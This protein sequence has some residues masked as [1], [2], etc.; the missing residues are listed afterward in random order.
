MISIFVEAEW[1]AC[2]VYI[3]S[4]VR[5]FTKELGKY[6]PVFLPLASTCFFSSVTNRNLCVDRGGAMN[7][8]F[9]SPFFILVMSKSPSSSRLA[10]FDANTGLLLAVLNNDMVW[11][12][13]LFSKLKCLKIK[14]ASTNSWIIHFLECT[15]SFSI[16]KCHIIRTMKY[17]LI[18]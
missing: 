14:R 1:L 9:G 8:F 16:I 10:P 18:S 2:D 11:F 13:L 6:P 15:Y 17:E 4:T 5:Y 12:S 7:L 3:C